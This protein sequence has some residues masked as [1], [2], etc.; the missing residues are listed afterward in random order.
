MKMRKDLRFKSEEETDEAIRLLSHRLE[1]SSLDLKTEKDILK[2]LKKLN[3]DKERIK[4][5]EAQVDLV[6][7]NRFVHEDLFLQRQAKSAELGVRRAQE[8][9]LMA[10]MDAIRSGEGVP[11]GFNAG[12]RISALLDEKAGLVEE[13][14]GKRAELHA[15]VVA[16]KLRQAEHRHPAPHRPPRT[17]GPTGPVRPLS[18]TAFAVTERPK[19]PR[20]RTHQRVR[21]WRGGGSC[22]TGCVQA[23]ETH[24][25]ARAQPSP[26]EG[27]VVR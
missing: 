3:G 17:P 2:D 13:L 26:R 14:K 7:A 6:K 1:T 19:R 23:T 24:V 11:D 27:G 8:K 10:R 25:R 22:G 16:F 5:W 18:P 9:A 20:P 12:A 21:P 15:A 4:Q